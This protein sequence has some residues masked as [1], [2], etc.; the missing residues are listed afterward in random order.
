VTLPEAQDKARA[1]REMFDGIAPRYDFVNRIMTFRMDVGWRRRCVRSLRLKPGEVVADVAC[2]TGDF[3]REIERTGARAIGLDFALEMLRAARTR[4]P[5]VQGDALKL[6]LKDASIDG[7]TC[8]FALRNV[9]DIGLLFDEF[10]RVLRAGGRVAILEVSRP[11]NP[12]LRW[13]HHVYFD[14]V[15]PVVG[16]LLSDADAYRYL[17]ESAAYLPSTAELLDRL[18]LAGFTDVSARQLGAGAAQMLTGAR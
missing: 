16:G 4:A 15:V 9:T 3:C 18:V 7:I 6:P 17:P 12:L 1:V 8:G 11:H 14:R 5:L 2:G 13:G 10:A